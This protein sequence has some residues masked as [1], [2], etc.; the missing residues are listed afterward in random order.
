MLKFGEPLA[1]FSHAEPWNPG[2]HAC[3]VTLSVQSHITP[4]YIDVQCSG[5]LGFFISKFYNFK[6]KLVNIYNLCI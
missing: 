1:G 3:S 6:T 4:S 5:P 2:P